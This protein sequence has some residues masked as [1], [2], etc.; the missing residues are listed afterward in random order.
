ML[1]KLWAYSKL[2]RI[3]SRLETDPLFLR[4]LLPSEEASAKVRINITELGRNALVLSACNEVE[5]LLTLEYRNGGFLFCPKIGSIM[6]HQAGGS[7]FQQSIDIAEVITEVC[8]LGIA[9]NIPNNQGAPLLYIAIPVDPGNV[10]PSKLC[11]LV[12]ELRSQLEDVAEPAI[13]N[14]LEH[15]ADIEAIVQENFGDEEED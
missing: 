14:Y 10:S 11:R 13:R 7:I 1:R 15:L 8:D 5:Q 2:A 12:V 3:K 9:L 4:V 6:S